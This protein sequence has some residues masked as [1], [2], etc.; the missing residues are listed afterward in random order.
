MAKKTLIQIPFTERQR[1]FLDSKKAN[2][3]IDSIAS[4]IRKLVD[5]QIFKDSAC[6]ILAS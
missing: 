3:E 6:K 2:D 1:Q 4:Y 5:D